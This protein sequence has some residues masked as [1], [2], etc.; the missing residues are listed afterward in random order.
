MYLFSFG[1]AEDDLYLKEGEN[2]VLLR[3]FYVYL[4][5]ATINRLYYATLFN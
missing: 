3:I 2:T 5:L 1:H 4:G